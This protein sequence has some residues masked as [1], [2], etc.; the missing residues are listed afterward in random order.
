MLMQHSQRLVE[1]GICHQLL[2]IF[3]VD[4]V[5]GRIKKPFAQVPKTG[6]AE[7][8]GSSSAYCTQQHTLLLKSWDL[9]CTRAAVACGYNHH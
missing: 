1:D 4:A 9:Y 8:A 5:K 3:K 2:H 7:V 6:Q